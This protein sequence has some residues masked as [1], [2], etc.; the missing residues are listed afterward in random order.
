MAL[1]LAVAPLVAGATA[2]QIPD[3]FTNLQ[4]LDKDIAK[5]QIVGI[6]RDWAGG[7]GVRCSHCHMTPDNL[8]GADFASDD[9]AAKRTARRMLEM[10]RALNREM[11]KD[12]PVVTEDGRDRHQIV[13]CYTCHRGL[14]TPPR[15][16]RVQLNRTFMTGGVEA[17]MTELKQLRDKH[18]G[19]GRYDFSGRNLAA[20]G[21]AL[22]EM[23]RSEDAVKWLTMALEIDPDSA[24]LHSTLGLVRLQDGDPDRARE[25]LDKAIAIDPDNPTAR[26]VKRQLEREP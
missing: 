4:L 24:Y 6:M 16:L 10:A 7:L 3:S 19:S 1:A 21:R 15:N 20:M 26:F 5:E 9:K 12:L 22:L 18:F 17:A 25:A 8:V 14:P 13:S 23:N 2:A 11:L